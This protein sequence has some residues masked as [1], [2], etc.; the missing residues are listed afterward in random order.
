M[1]KI[2]VMFTH[3]FRH[4]PSVLSL[5]NGCI[6]STNERLFFLHAWSTSWL[7]ITATIGENAFCINSWGVNLHWA[8][9]IQAFP[10]TYDTYKNGIVLIHKLSNKDDCLIRTHS[11]I[12]VNSPW[13]KTKFLL[14][15]PIIQP[16]LTCRHV[17]CTAVRWNGMNFEVCVS[18]SRYVNTFIC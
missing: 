8:I 2:K 1:P 10:R 6:I 18:E 16:P 7:H 5:Q 11:S 9:T 12:T 14:R 13:A 15:S 17:W 4:Q 3:A